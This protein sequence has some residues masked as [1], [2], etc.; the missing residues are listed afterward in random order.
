MKK[1]LSWLPL[2]TRLERTN[3]INLKFISLAV[4]LSATGLS[5][6]GCGGSGDIAKFGIEYGKAS[7][8]YNGSGSL[9]KGGGRYKVGSPY[10][11]NGKKYYPR[12][13]PGYDKIGN[14]SWYGPTFHGRKTANGEFFDMNRLTGA[15]PTLPLPSFVKVTN[16]KN[17]KSIVI[18]INDRGP[19]SHTR[20]LDVSKK[21]AEV[22]G[23]KRSGTARVRVTYVGRAPLNGD[24]YYG[25]SASRKPTTRMT[26]ASPHV[27]QHKG[28][29]A[30]HK[31][32]F[33]QAASF[34]S[35]RNAVRLGN[36]LQN[37]G[38]V[39]VV[40]SEVNGKTVYRVRVGPISNSLQAKKTLRR[41]VSAGHNDAT[42]VMN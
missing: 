7:P 31:G 30:H 27:N 34:T 21:T 19:Y 38:E 10:V 9:P 20:I 3:R 37:L 12:E 28:D 6:A 13:N 17:N 5:L 15:H 40:S 22:L 18:R 11:I 36:S 24:G 39:N 8:Y 4:V 33:I 32:V 25:R 23:F 41:V 42:L 1:N 2:E 14:A 29:S 35:H 16:L 26:S